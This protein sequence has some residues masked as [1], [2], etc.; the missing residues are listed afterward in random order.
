[1]ATNRNWPFI[2]QKGYADASLIEE[3][4]RYIFPE[5]SQPFPAVMD[6]SI[7]NDDPRSLGTEDIVLT[8]KEFVDELEA[9][10]ILDD[11]GGWTD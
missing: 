4:V 7:Y 8:G 3:D 9:R 5:H 1:M 10:G 2:W 6:T 11:I